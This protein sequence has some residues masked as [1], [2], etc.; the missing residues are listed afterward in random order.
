[1]NSQQS[2]IDLGVRVQLRLEGL[3]GCKLKLGIVIKRNE[4]GEN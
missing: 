2:A 1:M 3:V 4:G